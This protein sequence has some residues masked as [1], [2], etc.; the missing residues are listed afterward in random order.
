MVLP[1]VSFPE[2]VRRW[3]EPAPANTIVACF[4]CGHR[5]EILKEVVSL[6]CP[7]CNAPIEIAAYDVKG[8][9]THVIRTRGSV[10][11]QTRARY[12]GPKLVAGRLEVHGALASEY[13]CEDLVLGRLAKLEKPGTQRRLHVMP[14]GRVELGFP[15]QVVDACAGGVLEAPSI[16]VA[17]TLY[18]PRGGAVI[19]DRVSAGGLVLEKGGRLECELDVSPR[20]RPED[21]MADA[22]MPSPAATPAG[23][24]SP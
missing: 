9:E 3:I 16:E 15:V 17:G 10:V 14:G 13:A 12:D 21:P 19:A 2:Q 7:S 11:I 1:A 4:E 6:F 20:K 8:L 22:L 18:I 5:V 24:T 23:I